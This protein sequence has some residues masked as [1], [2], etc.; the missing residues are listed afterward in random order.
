MLG[1]VTVAALDVSCGGSYRYQ[2]L[3]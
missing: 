1:E 2:S 3:H